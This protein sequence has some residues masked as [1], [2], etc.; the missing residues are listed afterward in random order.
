MP[1]TVAY[2]N[3]AC[4]YVKGS[5]PENGY[6]IDPDAVTIEFNL[7]LSSPKCGKPG[8][9]AEGDTSTVHVVTSG[10][11]PPT[12]AV[13]LTFHKGQWKVHD[14]SN[15]CTN[16]V[17]PVAHG[18]EEDG[19]IRAANLINGVNRRNPMDRGFV[20]GHMRIFDT[21]GKVIGYEK[22]RSSLQ[23]PRKSLERLAKTE[24][25]TGYV[26]PP[27]YYRSK[28]HS[29]KLDGPVDVDRHE[30][31]R[32]ST[33]SRAEE[34]AAHDFGREWLD[35]P[36]LARRVVTGEQPSGKMAELIQK[37]RSNGMVVYQHVH[38]WRTAASLATRAHKLHLNDACDDD[39]VTSQQSSP[40]AQ[41]FQ[42]TA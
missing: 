11:L 3:H 24:F 40:S 5:S 6:A 28:H 15:L 39:K 7:L 31:A 41:K 20:E 12:R 2:A 23:R 9:A 26:R 16:V 17:P 42:L 38:T 13:H 10:A 37:M 14:F 30:R 22:T 35:N 32:A 33:R 34:L 21:S 8:D 36:S 29:F 27:Q 18:T 4:R 25:P 19:R 1:S